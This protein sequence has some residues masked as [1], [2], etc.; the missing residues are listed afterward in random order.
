M[1][2]G[3]LL[4]KLDIIDAYTRI[5]LSR[6]LFVLLVPAL[7]FNGMGSSFST[8]EFSTLWVVP[9]IAVIHIT[10]GFAI[11]FLTISITRP[12]E[13]FRITSVLALMLGNA[14]NIPLSFVESLGETEAFRDQPDAKDEGIKVISLYLI[15][16]SFA[17]WMV[18]Y[19]LM[20]LGG[21][22][23][24]SSSQS[25]EGYA[26]G[27][28]DDDDDQKKNKKNKKKSKMIGSSAE[29]TVPSFDPRSTSLH[30]SSMCSSP[31]S[32][33]SMRY[34]C[35]YDD[36][37]SSESGS[38]SSQQES[39]GLSAIETTFGHSAVLNNSDLPTFDEKHERPSLCA[40]CGPLR[41]AREWWLEQKEASPVLAFIC[42][43]IFTPPVQAILLALIVASIPGLSDVIFGNDRPLKPVGVTAEILANTVVG[44]S[45]LV[46]GA[47]LSSV[48]LGEASRKISRVNTAAL[49]FMKMI[50]MG[51]LGIA[52]VYGLVHAGIL[53]RDNKMLLFILMIQAAVPTAQS[54]I[55]IAEL[56][57]TDSASVSAFLFF[58]YVASV[59]CLT[60]SVTSALY[61]VEIIQN[62]G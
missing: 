43:R 22:E 29:F 56:H 46:L 51:A 10:M 36:D 8:S 17:L 42:D 32:S 49:I 34:S 5:K 13:H 18:G 25:Y 39:A 20:G 41:E 24:G 52:L 23:D 16:S 9:A 62:G 38:V 2:I 1:F 59:P 21:K 26:Y 48:S 57:Q 53:D 11:G 14:G 27:S 55:I 44:L 15:V 37:G 7:L 19:P 28:D 31:V 54:V 45:M 40:S 35:S 30:S 47:S 6:M 61:V 33:L 12:P 58:M 4:G 60:L 50:V 3:V